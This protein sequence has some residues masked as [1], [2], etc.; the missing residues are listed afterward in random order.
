MLRLEV[1]WVQS[2]A[3]CQVEPLV[4]SCFSTRTVSVTPSFARW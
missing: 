4:S 3:A 2:P 1:N